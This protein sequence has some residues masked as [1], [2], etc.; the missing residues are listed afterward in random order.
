MDSFESNRMVPGKIVISSY[1]LM[2]SLEIYISGQIPSLLTLGS[3]GKSDTEFLS[4]TA[5]SSTR[6]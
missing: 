3:F 2:M 5:Q 6:S 4:D 1:G